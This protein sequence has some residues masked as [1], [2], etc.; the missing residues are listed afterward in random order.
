MKKKAL[1]IVLAVVIAAGCST[2]G[3][4][5][6]VDEI[7][8]TH[9]S[10]AL[11][12]K[13]IVT[14]K[15]KEADT[16]A[17]EGF[18]D[19]KTSLSEATKSAHYGNKAQAEKLA[20]TGLQ[21][22]EKAIADTQNAN[23]FLWEVIEYRIRAQKSG[24][25]DLFADEFDAV[26]NNL[27]EVTLLLEHGKKNEAKDRRPDLIE[28]YSDLEVRARKKGVVELAKADF[29][30]ALYNDA[31]DY[32][33]KTFE[34][35]NAELTMAISILDKNP[36]EKERAE[37]HAET[38]SRLA[39][40]ASQI[41]DLA[42]MFERRD[43]S[44]EDIILWYWK[45]LKKINEPIK[46]DIDFG[47]RNPQVIALMRGKINALLQ[48][49]LIAKD[50]EAKQQKYIEELKEKLKD[51]EKGFEEQN[52]LER[53]AKRRFEH[54]QS[55]FNDNEA[56]VYRQGNNVLISAH[57]FYFPSGGAELLAQN[58]G[59][60]NKI[61]NSIRQFP[62]SKLRISGHTDSIGDENINRPLSQKRADNIAKFLIE[63]GNID[64][65]NI[66]IKGYGESR[67]VAT[68]E[69]KEG[70]TLNRRIEVLIV[71]E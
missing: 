28:S 16:F 27:K 70:R 36:D 6:T 52:R 45:Q 5:L 33:P 62:T 18:L 30:E 61:I 67:P 71:N 40:E 41:A 37:K 44:L 10:I 11:L 68:N 66:S 56:Q 9:D 8:K 57:G 26:E 25:P 65:S 64:A 32:A 17:P 43:Y 47:N 35:A 42:R 51:L 55:L 49:Q 29:K 14:A 38:A 21:K 4:R 46:G 31:E 7:Y 1:W 2:G 50:I 39:E 15:E 63:V 34:A 13:K 12:D 60:L 22:I 69:T 53:E 48:A 58:F 3:K 54:I 24:A 59:L 23:T 19:A 20:K